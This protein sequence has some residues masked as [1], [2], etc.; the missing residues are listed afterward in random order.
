M[1]RVA[2]YSLSA[3]ASL[4][5]GFLTVTSI[6]YYR[7]IFTKDPHQD[8]LIPPPHPSEAVLRVSLLAGL[9][10]ASVL[11]PW[12]LRKDG[13]EGLAFAASITLVGVTLVWFAYRI[14]AT[15]RAGDTTME[16]IKPQF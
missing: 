7:W 4:C 15:F 16:L 3:L 9:F 14:W 12:L 11:I 6:A 1:K 13:R 8:P 5:W 2:T 10:L